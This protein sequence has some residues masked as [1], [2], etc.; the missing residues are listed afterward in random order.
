M[1]KYICD[2]GNGELE[3][4]ADSAQ[5]AA[6]EYVDRGDWGNDGGWVDVYVTER[7]NDCDHPRMVT[8]NG[9]PT[10]T[11]AECGESCTCPDGEEGEID[12]SDCIIH[13]DPESNY[14]DRERIKIAIDVPI[15][16]L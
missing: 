9:I 10:G 4:E 1:T 7:L 14:G 12:S 13:G 15:P 5:E 16:G 6:Q 3:I 2:D 8:D 11:C